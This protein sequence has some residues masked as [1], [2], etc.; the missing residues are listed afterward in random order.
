MKLT[1]VR[2]HICKYALFF[3]L[4]ILLLKGFGSIT[5]FKIVSGTTIGLCVYLSVSFRDTP[6]LV[7]SSVSA[8]VAAIYFPIIHLYGFW[9]FLF[10]LGLPRAFPVKYILCLVLAGIVLIEV[11]GDSL[12]LLLPP[13]S[14]LTIVF[15]G[16]LA[17]VIRSHR[18]TAFL[19]VCVPCIALTI[20]DA[21]PYG[22]KVQIGYDSSAPP[23]IAM[24]KVLAR[25][26]GGELKPIG[27]VSDGLG[28]TSLIA[29]T[30]PNNAPLQIIL[31][32]HDQYSSENEKHI[33][34][35]NLFQ[36]EPWGEN[37]TLGNQYL[38]YALA[39]DGQLFWNLGG[40]L[41]RNGTVLLASIQNIGQGSSLLIEPFVVRDGNKVFIA[42]SDPFCDGA[43]PYQRNFIFEVVRKNPAPR[44]LN[45]MFLVCSA[46]AD[47]GSIG[48][49]AS[50]LILLVITW[51]RFSPVEGD[52]RIIGAIAWPHESSAYSGVMMSLVDAGHPML[53]GRDNTRIL[54]VA[55]HET[56]TV[57]RTEKLVLAGSGSVV[58]VN[59]KRVCVEDLPLGAI[60]GVIDARAISGTFFPV[61]RVDGVTIIGTDSPA[62]QDWTKWAQFLQ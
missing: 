27:Q 17:W 30:G 9:I 46:F 15:L 61:A 48:Y 28:I 38:N 16:L 3:C 6:S 55:P 33:E 29:K 57:L 44:V 2:G 21:W 35:G 34:R 51:I 37:L 4:S 52:V 8:I 25:V 31:V 50:P 59:G 12:H 45:L 43:V 26:V 5:L 36:K 14:I 13:T 24:G 42:D 32:D 54:V 60:Q 53:I 22:G 56:V 18:K 19:I 1:F 39:N 7:V 20:K 49:W 40:R 62:K 41:S 58:K 10:A 11:L 47:L 23:G